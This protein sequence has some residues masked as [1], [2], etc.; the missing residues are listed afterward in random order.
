[1][2]SSVRCSNSVGRAKEADELETKKTVAQ[3][4]I[5]VRYRPF[6]PLMEQE[7]QDSFLRQ[8]DGDREKENH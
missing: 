4:L 7:E 8:G 1:M 3:A 2:F 5:F 6:F